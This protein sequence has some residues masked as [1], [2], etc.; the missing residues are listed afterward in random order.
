MITADDVFVGEHRVSKFNDL[1]HRQA[2][3]HWS[4]D[5]E[6]QSYGKDALNLTMLTS[7]ATQ[8]T[9]HEIAMTNAKF[10]ISAY[11]HSDALV[12]AL[13][14]LLTDP[15][16]DGKFKHSGLIST[17]HADNL[18]Q[19]VDVKP[20]A[21]V[22]ELD[23]YMEQIPDNA[24]GLGDYMFFRPSDNRL[25]SSYSGNPSNGIVQRALWAVRRR[26]LLSS[27]ANVN[28]LQQYPTW[29]TG[30]TTFTDLL[31]I[32]PNGFAI[33]AVNYIKRYIDDTLSLKPQR[34]EYENMRSILLRD[35][36]SYQSQQAQ[37]RRRMAGDKFA[38]YWSDLKRNISS[39]DAGVAHME[40]ASIPMLDPGK[41]SSRTWGIEIET[42]RANQTSRPAGWTAVTDGSLPSGDGGCSCDCDSCYAGDDHCEESSYDCYEGDN[43]SREFVSPILNH[44]NSSGLRQLCNDLGTDPD[45]DSAPGIHVH[46]GASDLS[47]PDVTNVMLSYSAIEP[48]LKPLLHRKTFNYCKPASTD[49]L[50]WW[51]AKVREFRRVSP[52]QVP[53]PRDLAYDAPNDRYLDVNLHSLSK[54]GTIEFRAMGA[55]YDYDHLS[56][57]AWLVRELVNVSKLGIDQREWTRCRSIADVVAVLRKYGSEIPDSTLIDDALSSKDFDLSR[58]IRTEALG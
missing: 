38:T 8:I 24:N 29:E 42:V 23:G 4:S 26:Q 13:P 7:N 51:L 2:E 57:W 30:G 33:E 54:H 47:V 44:F 16:W 3:R 32:K 48:L 6:L 56:R 40:F 18:V 19:Y 5:P 9:S 22:R 49:T 10:V 34:Y 1:V 43:S 21:I 25:T 14:R 50:R 11:K 20:D 39:Q 28:G 37:L 12:K 17:W 45:E 27:L 58:E 31:L 41:M 52:D 55:W 36:E 15:R 53:Q 46:V 35:Q